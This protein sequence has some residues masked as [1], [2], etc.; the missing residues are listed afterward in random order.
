MILANKSFFIRN[1]PVLLIGIHQEKDTEIEKALKS[2]GG[3]NWRLEERL[4]KQTL[5]IVIQMNPDSIF[6]INFYQLITKHV[7]ATSRVSFARPYL[8]KLMITLS[9]KLMADQTRHRYK[10]RRCISLYTCIWSRILEALKDVSLSCPL[11]HLFS[12][13]GLFFPAVL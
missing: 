4:K 10:A 13:K 2:W 1:I 7:Y 3:E 11:P 12:R 9:H 8:N 6:S 5:T